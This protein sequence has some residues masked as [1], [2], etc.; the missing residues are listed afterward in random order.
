MLKP[1]F[2]RFQKVN[3]PL[4][5][6]LV[7]FMKKLAEY[8]L[9]DMALIYTVDESQHV[10][11][12]LTPWEMR[13]SVDLKQCAVDP[14]V[15]MYLRGDPL[16]N[17]YANGHTMTWSGTT[18]R[19]QYE[20][21]R[22]DK[23]IIETVLTDGRGIRV[24]HRVMWHTGCEALRVSTS[25]ENAASAPVILEML[26][27]INL[28]GMT[29]F[30]PDDASGCLILHRAR[31]MWSAEGR[32]TSE[33][34]ESLQMERSWTGHAARVLRFGQVGS[35]PVRGW[36]PFV[37][38]EDSAHQVTWAMQLACPSSWQ[39][40]LRRKDDA[41][42]LT[43][44][45][46]DYDFGHW[47]RTIQPGECFDSPEAYVTVGTGPAEEVAQRLLSIHRENW[48]GRDSVLPVVFNE[49][50]TTWGCPSHENMVRL[51]EALKGHD[52]D[53][54]VMDAGWYGRE[55]CG[56]SDCG[57][58]WIPNTALF[59][60]GLK[61]TTDVIHAAGFKAGIWFE[62]ETCAPRSAVHNC[63]EML[64]TRNGSV[65]DTD[66]RRFLDLRT[67]EARDHLQKSMI[68][69]LRDCGFDYVKVDYN[70]C[71][72]VGCDSPDGL[73]EGLRQ[74]Q[75]ETLRLFRG[76]QE[77][78]PGL[79]LENCASGGHRLEPSLLSASWLSSFSDAHEQPEIPVIAAALHRL[80]LP[81]QS[82]IWSVLRPGDSLRRITYSLAATLLGVMCLSGDVYSLNTEQW[83]KVDE[84]IRFYRSVQH[85]IRDGVS[86]ITAE[87][88]ES[89]HHPVG[90]QAVIRTL[91]NETL[92]VLH[93]FGGSLPEQVTLDIPVSKE[94]VSVLEGDKHAMTLK[95]GKLTVQLSDNFD[96][97]A[98]LLH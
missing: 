75:Q 44:G 45:L 96:A 71:I 15:Q 14:L 92:I 66:G 30:A 74:N 91:G 86:R 89:W 57:G 47:A 16:P 19:L 94:I 13:S 42:S 72:G 56:W 78:L 23:D 43:A 3:I 69:Q 82:L 95:E 22:V 98:V 34:L 18:A 90:W 27:S 93:T 81:G 26:S 28:S 79:M 38:L 5:E 88:G 62:P 1:T 35:M 85:I 33:T 68:D 83:A 52:I 67:P 48:V 7:R 4:I 60:L 59:P 53:Y 54:V 51:T 84:G 6:R 39:M 21:Q 31:S 80:V 65:I 25:V 11:M 77:Q 61:G 87:L 49:Y 9:G 8:S 70:D 32:F 36:F 10:G 2:N 76:M 50:C 97:V 63:K 12:T 24:I 37:A 64:L 17:S 46:A 29:P 20:T 73:G 55:D 40:E 41:V 58:D